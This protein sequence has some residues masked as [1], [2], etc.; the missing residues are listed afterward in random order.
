MECPL[1]RSSQGVTIS[2]CLFTRLDG[3]GI[4]VGGYARGLVI[5]GN[6]FAFLG[7]S[8]IAAW[9]DTSEALNANGT[10]ALPTGYKIGPDG[11]GGNQPRGTRVVGN[12]C[13]EIGL[14]EKQSSLWFSAVSANATVEG[15]VFFNG[16]R[17]A[18]NYNA[19]V[20]INNCLLLAHQPWEWIF[21]SR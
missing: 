15:N 6:E 13:R 2:D 12:L 7:G 4:F 16:P 19:R 18:L 11:R 8:A 14:W 9:G 21:S 5:S 17:A 3:L 20:T 10:R 1:P